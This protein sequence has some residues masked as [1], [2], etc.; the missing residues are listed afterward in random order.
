M[1][2]LP[3]PQTNHQ[4]GGAYFNGRAQRR[5]LG[6]MSSHRE[7]LSLHRTSHSHTMV[8][9]NKLSL[10]CSESRTIDEGDVNMHSNQSASGTCGQPDQQA[11]VQRSAVIDGHTDKLANV[12]TAMK[13]RSLEQIL[14]L[15]GPPADNSTVGT[16]GQETYCGASR[17]SHP[18]SHA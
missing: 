18:S 5:K 6:S 14:C 16:K 17:E 15:L 13:K 10:H 7:L 3:T 11:R 8:E 12:Q 2:S 1:Y 4:V 9:S